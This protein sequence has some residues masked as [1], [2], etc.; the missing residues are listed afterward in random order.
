[1]ENEKIIRVAHIIGKWIGGGVEAVV[2]NYYR[3]IDRSKIQFDF[4]CDED[5]TDI[6]FNEI[7]ALGGKVILIPPYQNIFKYNKILKI[8]L[9]KGEYKIIHSHI[10]AL[11]VFPL[12]I[13]KKS[14]IQIRIAHSHSTT[15]NIEWKK[16]II[17]S[18]LKPFSKIYATD[19]FACTEHAGKWLFGKS[20]YKKNIIFILNNAIDIKNYKFDS[21]KRKQFREKNNINSDTFVIGHAGRFVTQKNH[22]F[23]ID[24]F[25]K[26]YKKNKNSLLILV[27][28]GPLQGKIKEKINNLKLEDKVLFLNQRNDLNELYSA[29]DLFLFPSLYEGLGMVIIEA[30]TSGCPCLVSTEVPR[31][32]KLTDLVKF[33]DLNSNVDIWSYDIM[34]LKKDSD[35]EKYEKIMSKTQYNIITEAKKLEN[36]YIEL[37]EKNEKSSDFNLVK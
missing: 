22:E 37:E 4:F 5:S 31:D 10:N 18:L 21:E 28:Q 17:K 24:I 29:F 14:G 9:E 30:Q 1:M 34:S 7:Q 12:R 36:K 35:R 16:N 2:M 20:A 26:L 23:L 33:E 8:E 13:A 25:D 11:S 19:F 27:G 32:V 6:P 15:N 3:N